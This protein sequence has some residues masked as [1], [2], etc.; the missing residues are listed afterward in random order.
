MD[1]ALGRPMTLEQFLAWE[2]RQEFKHEFDGFQPVAM[3]GV[4]FAHSIIQRN[5]ILAI[6][7]RLRGQRCQ[8]VGSD[9]KIEV[10]GRIRY[11]D[12]F[13]V[14]TPVA[15]RETVV[16]DPVVVLEILSEGTA[17]TDRVTKR[18]EYGET[19]SIQRYVVFQQTSAEAMVFSRDNGWT[20]ETV[21]GDAVLLMPEIGV[22]VPL[23]EIYEGLTFD[24]S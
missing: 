20:L 6:G 13:V 10:V 22:E 7:S 24:A 8:I 16:R 4:R 5:L 19:P 23:P 11:P 21:A 12:A 18:F 9:C 17:V 2:E 1:V 14:C 3:A 15:G